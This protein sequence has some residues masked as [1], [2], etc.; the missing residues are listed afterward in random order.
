MAASRVFL[1][2]YGQ[3]KEMENEVGAVEDLMREHG[4]IRR[5]ILVYRHSAAKLHSGGPV[6]PKA[7]ERAARLLR[8]FGEDYHE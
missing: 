4:V 5:A 6:D 8:N 3:A 7:L 2:S 1:R